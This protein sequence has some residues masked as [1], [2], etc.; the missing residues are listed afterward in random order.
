MKAFVDTSTLYALWVAEDANHGAAVSC[1]EQLRVAEAALTT[2]NYVLLEGASLVQRRHGF[3]AA[4]KVLARASELVDV[5]WM[6]RKLHHQAVLL[7]NEAGRRA[8]SLV[9]CASF[10]VMR[11]HGITRAVA[12]DAHFAEAGFEVLPRADR[13]AERKGAYRATRKRQPSHR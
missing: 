2:T 13:I 4:K 12:F 3:D 1:F 10:A 11:E 7:W 5:V 8:L 9:D 6:D